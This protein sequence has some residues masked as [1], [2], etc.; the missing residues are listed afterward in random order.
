M[1]ASTSSFETTRSNATNYFATTKPVDTRHQ[2]GGAVGFPIVR[3]KTFFFGDSE[4]GRI[5]RETTTLSTLPSATARGGQF[6]RTIID[7]LTRLPFPGNQIPASRMDAVAASILGYVPLPQTSAATNNFAYNSP[8]DQ[9]QQTWDVRIDHVFS[10]SH[11]AY[12]RVS[13]QRLENKPN[14]PLPPDANGN[15][16]ASGAS[17]ISDNKS[18]VVVHNAVWSRNVI[19][20]IRVGYN[21][22]D[23]DEIVPPQDLRGDWH[24]RRGHQQPGVLADRDHRVSHA[25]RVERAQCRRFEE[26]SRCP[27]TYR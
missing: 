8:S 25:G 15:Y 20:S 10:P 3:S 27:A 6:S 4:T 26:S 19:G 17:D 21:R 7:P 12:V 18:V 16:V 24:S 9:D 5:Q 2:F 14:S 23:W 11:N 1:A 22:I 13:S